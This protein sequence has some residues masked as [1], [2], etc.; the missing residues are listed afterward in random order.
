MSQN[1]SE[2]LRPGFSALSDFSS[3][4]GKALEAIEFNVVRMEKSM[5][6]TFIK[7]HTMDE[8]VLNHEKRLKLLESEYEAQR[9][10]TENIM[11]ITAGM[12]KN[13]GN[14]LS[15]ATKNLH[16]EL[17]IQR[18]VTKMD[19]SA[20]KGRLSD[21]MS[22]LFSTLATNPQKIYNPSVMPSYNPN[23]TT[24]ESIRF[25]VEK[26]G[27]LEDALGLQNKVNDNFSKAIAKDDVVNDIYNSLIDEISALNNELTK[28]QKENNDLKNSMREMK[29]YQLRQERTIA[30]ILEAL[31]S[32]DRLKLLREEIRKTDK[33]HR[34]SMVSHLSEIPEGDQEDS[35]GD[36]P[37]RRKAS[38]SSSHKRRKRK[39]YVRTIQQ[40]DELD[41]PNAE[42]EDDEEQGGEGE[43]EGGE[44]GDSRPASA[45]KLEDG[46]EI[47]SFTAPKRAPIKANF[48]TLVKKEKKKSR[49]S[50]SSSRAEEE[51]GNAE[52]EQFEGEEGILEEG[53]QEEEV[54]ADVTTE[55]QQL[56]E[57]E[58][59]PELTTETRSKPAPAK[60]PKKKPS[61]IVEKV[62]RIERERKSRDYQDEEE[63]VDQEEEGGDDLD[64]DGEEEEEEPQPQKRRGPSQ[65]KRKAS[66]NKSDNSENFSERKAS[67]YNTN[68]MPVD[69]K[70][71]DHRKDTQ[72]ASKF[73]RG[74][75]DE[76]ENA[77]PEQAKKA[78][79]AP[80]P[81]KASQEAKNNDN[82][83]QDNNDNKNE[84]GKEFWLSNDTFD[85]A[86][87]GGGDPTQD[88]GA[89]SVFT[90]ESSFFEGSDSMYNDES[91]LGRHVIDVIEANNIETA[92]VLNSLREEYN[93]RLDSLE[94]ALATF[95]RI[96]FV[97][98]DL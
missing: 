55:Q 50:S 28:S 34:V 67:K 33:A 87:A 31:S 62:K 86:A 22:E 81:A 2:A 75:G 20:L 77:T 7:I 1:V 40:I 11:K 72:R 45:E 57:S 51:Q 32:K 70:P 47:P 36:N 9:A 21:S 78:A 83:Q 4:L 39:T 85:P 80:A 60:T 48:S 14:Q 37:S 98:D 23:F 84:E 10:V 43:G 49:K 90:A 42:Q 97:I 29:N 74:F 8:S 27:H 79:A 63:P 88:D 15:D 65:E 94:N 53:E 66:S 68:L 56:E 5:D 69:S 13:I 26:M 58:A 3:I 92:N 18:T 30:E 12:E 25:L 16:K 64:L 44:Q 46:T 95:K 19:I 93:D 96:A 89:N 76:E 41:D 6:G 54:E 61:K 24:D 71:A 82:E 17:I 52:Q 73:Y 38:T 35:D 59:N 91:S